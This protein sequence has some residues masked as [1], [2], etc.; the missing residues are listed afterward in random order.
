MDEKSALLTLER[1]RAKTLDIIEPTPGASDQRPQACLD[2]VKF[3]WLSKV[4]VR[5]AI[6]AFDSLIGAIAGGQDENWR[7]I[8]AR[9]SGAQ[10]INRLP[11]LVASTDSTICDGAVAVIGLPHTRPDS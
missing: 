7:V 2:L 4:V 9:T 8:A 11:A 10:T 3:E 5:T 1:E 6:Q